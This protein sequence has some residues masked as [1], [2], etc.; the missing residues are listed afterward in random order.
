MEKELEYSLED[1]SS[2]VKQRLIYHFANPLT[3][4]WIIPK[5]MPF[6]KEF[7]NEV[8]KLTELCDQSSNNEISVYED[9]PD[10]SVEKCKCCGGYH[11]SDMC[12]YD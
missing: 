2:I 3:G 1:Q 6:M 8:K 10:E 9:D 12:C 5:N 4:E 7:L 11:E